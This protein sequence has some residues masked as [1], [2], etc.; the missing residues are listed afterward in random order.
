MKKKLFYF[1]LCLLLTKNANSQVLQSDVVIE[2]LPSFSINTIG[3]ST[4]FPSNIWQESDEENLILLFKKIGTKPLTPASQKAI[5][6][7]LTQDS[8]APQKKENLSQKDNAFLIERLNTLFRLGAFDETLSIIQQLPEKQLTEDILKIKFYA[9]LMIGKI[10]DAEPILENITDVSFLDK[11]RINLFLEKEERNKAILSYEILKESQEKPSDLFSSLAENIL[12]EIETPLIEETPKKEDAFL[13]ARSKTTPFNFQN[14][15]LDIQKILTLLPYTDI[16]KRIQLAEQLNLTGDE[17]KKIY[18]L[19]LHNLKIDKNHLKR[20][21]LFQKI[22]TTIDEKEKIKYLNEFLKLAFSD[23]IIL[24][25][26]PVIESELDKI[27]A[28]PAYLPTAFYAVQIYAL[29]NNLEKANEWY[30]LLKNSPLDIY[31]KQ[32]MMLIPTLQLLG[33]GFSNDLNSL[34]AHFCTNTTDKDCTNFYK[35]LS[36]EAYEELSLKKDSQQILVPYEYLKV[37]NKNKIGENLIKAILDLN[38]STISEKQSIHSFIIE[39]TP[40]SIEKEFELERML[41]Q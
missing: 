23:K 14:Q 36:N 15:T 1:L 17:L 2:D 6:L 11:A 26:A 10:S 5:T 28:N 21:E 16:E 27:I 25:I 8:T 3:T 12:L 20:A 40:K 33:A 18:N 19:P 34:I 9:L 24:H 39:N 4:V 38:D 37:E 32:R 29:R 22:Q 31:Q 13:L 30:T 7:L 41:Y 35:R